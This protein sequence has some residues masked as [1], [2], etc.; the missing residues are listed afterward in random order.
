MPRARNTKPPSVTKEVMA[1]QIKELK[2]E[3][4]ETN[5]ALTERRARVEN[6]HY[7]IGGLRREIANLQLTVTGLRG[8]AGHDKGK[9]EAYKEVSDEFMKRLFEAVGAD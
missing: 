4:F 9:A 8:D 7:E 1:E 2:R 5:Q 3:L 6:L